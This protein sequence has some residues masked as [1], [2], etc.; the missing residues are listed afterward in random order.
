MKVAN[1]KS[2]GLSWR[3]TAAFK[4]TCPSDVSWLLTLYTIQCQVQG[5]L[6]KIDHETMNGISEMFPYKFIFLV[7]I[8]MF[9]YRTFLRLQGTQCYSCLRFLFSRSLFKQYYLSYLQIVYIFFFWSW[10]P[11]LSSTDLDKIWTISVRIA[12]TACTNWSVS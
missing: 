2:R 1:I 3:R 12:E 8:G 6:S 10:N 7:L 4:G 9:S 5:G 11:T